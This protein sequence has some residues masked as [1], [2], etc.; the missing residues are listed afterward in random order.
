MKR[1]L[2]SLALASKA[3]ALV[4]AV[5]IYANSNTATAEDCS[6]CIPPPDCL[7]DCWGES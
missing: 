7:P 1:L 3:L 6:P 5:M 2:V 4:A